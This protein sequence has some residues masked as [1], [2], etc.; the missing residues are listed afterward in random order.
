MMTVQSESIEWPETGGGR[1]KPEQ[2]NVIVP[3]PVAPWE[4]VPQRGVILS[5]IKL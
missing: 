5:R 1:M 2:Q 3:S 4:R